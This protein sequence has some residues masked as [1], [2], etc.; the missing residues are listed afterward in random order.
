MPPGVE[1]A[2]LATPLQAIAG[3]LGDALPQPAPTR[4]APVAIDNRAHPRFQTRLKG[5]LLSQDGRCNCSCIVADVSEGGARVQ[6]HDYHL[7]PSRVFLFLADSGQFF[8]CDVRW[9]RDSEIGL[10]FIDTVPSAVRRD[11]LKLCARA[12]AA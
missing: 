3:I 10:R 9:R 2:R 6:P 11:L 4:R 7:V 8:E 1:I 5:R 12:P